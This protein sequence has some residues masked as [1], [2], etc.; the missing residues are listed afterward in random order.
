M[1]L[2]AQ[3]MGAHGLAAAAGVIVGATVAAAATP[4]AAAE[5]HRVTLPVTA[6]LDPA[7][8]HPL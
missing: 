6:V 2:A 1:V 4:H 8:K 5:D 3:V 7:P